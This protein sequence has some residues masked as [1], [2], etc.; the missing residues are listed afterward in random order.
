MARGGGGQVKGVGGGVEVEG[1]AHSHEF[2]HPEF[3][4][5][6]CHHSVFM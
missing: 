1:G 3:N 2:K 6:K 4:E 5:E